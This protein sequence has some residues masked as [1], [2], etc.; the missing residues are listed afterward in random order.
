MKQTRTLAIENMT[1]AN[2]VRHVQSALHGIRGV[3]V[4]E[5]A[6]GSAILE[7]DP[8][9]VSEQHITSTVGDAGYPARISQQQ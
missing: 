4:K 5:V 2:C 3:T 8:Q 7:Y 9:E 1:C 6:I